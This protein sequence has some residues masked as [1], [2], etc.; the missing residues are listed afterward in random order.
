MKK[1]T[2]VKNLLVN[3]EA[4]TTY[5]EALKLINY[6]LKLNI[7]KS[8][9]KIWLPFDNELSNI[10]KALLEMWGGQIILSNL[11]IGLDFYLYQPDEFDLI[12]TNPP[13][14]NRTNLFNRLHD[15]D[16]PFIILNSTMMFNNQSVIEKLCLYSNKYTFVMPRTR[17][18]F[19]RYDE[20]TN[21]VKT[22]KYGASF[23]SFWLAYKVKLP[24]TFN[25]I[26]DTGNETVIEKLDIE[27]NAIID[28][29]LN[30]FNYFDKK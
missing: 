12:I 2:L 29:H 3:D 25:Y 20:E 8:N 18:K 21:T 14:S 5:N 10:Y 30:L 4:Y 1:E 28:N 7:I 9:M 27:G 13:F 19:L 24:E 26:K 23:Y 17:M 16:K 22:S 6:L 11:E 15:L